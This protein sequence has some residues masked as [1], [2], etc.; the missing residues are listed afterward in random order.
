LE[1]NLFGLKE[2]LFVDISQLTDMAY[3]SGL[4]DLEQLIMALETAYFGI[5]IG[6]IMMMPI[7]D[8]IKIKTRGVVKCL[9]SA[10]AILS[11]SLFVIKEYS[12]SKYFFLLS[13]IVITAYIIMKKYYP[14]ILEAQ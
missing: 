1:Y 8:E 11:V 3:F 5:I 7:D 14:E 6:L 12:F 13:F 4:I 10:L 2:V 9:I